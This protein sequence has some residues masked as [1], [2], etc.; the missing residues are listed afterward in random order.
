MEASETTGADARTAAVP[1]R[2][3]SMAARTGLGLVLAGTVCLLLYLDS[4]RDAGL[5]YGAVA[6]GVTVIA[7]EEFARLAGK[8]GLHP[9]RPALVLGGAALFALQW[10]VRAIGGFQPWSAGYA[11]LAAMTI[12][13]LAARVLRART[14]HALESAATVVM[15]WAYVPMMVGFLTATRLE[16]GVAGLITVLAVCKGSSSAAY[17]VGSLLG[18]RKLLPQVS[19]NKTVAGAVGA[20]AGAV[21]IALALSLSPLSVMAVEVAPAFGLLVGLAALLGDLAE[22]LLKREAGL[23]DSGRLLPGFG[24]MLD[25][26]DDLLFAAPASFLFLHVHHLSTLG[27]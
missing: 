22:S 5:V 8:A 13:L 27:A 19:P 7:L 11:L 14:E 16:W 24:G 9:S 3:A 1:S 2:A 21:A 20:M 26:L 15:G 25:M 18:R 23:K 6:L 17:F 10:S 4:L 12:C